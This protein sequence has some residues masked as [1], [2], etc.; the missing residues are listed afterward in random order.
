MTELSLRNPI[1]VAMACIAIVVFAAVVT[2]RMP[3]DTFPELT[4]PVLVVGTLAPGLGAKDVEKTLNW[5]FEKYVSA[6][7]GVDHVESLSRNNLSIVYVWL[8]WGTDLGA[9]QTLVQQQVQFAM[10]AVPKSLGILPPFVLQYDPSNAPVVQVAVYGGGMTGPQIYDYAMNE[11]EPLLEGISGVASASVNGGRQRQIN[12]IVDPSRAQ[13][14]GMTSTQV[15]GAVHDSNALLPSGE[16]INKRFDAIVYTN[17]IPKVVQDIGNA[18]VKRDGEKAVR[19]KDVARVEDGASPPTQTVSINGQDAVYLNVLRV[20]GGN[21]IEIVDQVKDKIA[22][23][24]NLPPGVHVEPIFDQSTFVR[25]TYHGL[26]KEV[27]QALVLVALVILV[28]L[29]SFR[30]TLVVSLAIP[31]SFAITLLVLYWHGETLNAFTL[32]GL[33]LVMGRLVDD[34]VVVLESIHRHRKRG[35]SA[36]D[37]A[38]HGTRAVVLPVLASTLTTMAVLLPVLLFAGLAQRLF[39]PLAITVAVAMAASYFVSIAVTPV[40]CRYLLG[41]GEPGRFAK[42][43]ERVIEGLAHGY[44]RTLDKVIPHGWL[45]ILSAAIL[46]SASVWVT[47]RLPSQFFP[48]IDESMERIYVRAAPGTSLEDSS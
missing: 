20:P 29:Q 40:M 37:A 48:P 47:T 19:I 6:T 12:V 35:M 34:A 2:P 41:H 21:T 3:V 38:L 31:L 42:R 39:V 4:P 27:V 22:H 14:R 25:S 16:L 8:K 10:S 11:I 26:K 18:V 44:A 13:A 43:I 36:R 7:P 9:A 28:F 33:T 30:G 5:R 1:A 23:L 15:A 17:A 45:V 32:G 24:E 46:V